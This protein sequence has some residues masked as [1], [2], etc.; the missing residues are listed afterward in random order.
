VKLILDANI[1]VEACR[2]DEARSRFWAAFVPLLP[3][4]YLA[5]IVAYELR[6]NALDCATRR[7][8]DEM[9]GPMHRTGRLVTPSFADWVEASDIV[10]AIGEK[11]RAWRF[12]LPALLNDV[13]IALC[14]RRIG[15]TVVTR[16]ARDFRLIRRHRPFSLRVLAPA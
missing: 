12:K 1:Y 5:A 10:S 8:I 7:V 11:N 2:S 3:V 6:V 13:L 14:A 15:A 9:I 4:T 16:N